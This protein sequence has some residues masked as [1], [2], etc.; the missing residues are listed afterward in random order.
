MTDTVYK[1]NVCKLNIQEQ[2]RGNE[3]WVTYTSENKLGEELAPAHALAVSSQLWA[4]LCHVCGQFRSIYIT[5]FTSA[6]NQDFSIPECW[7]INSSPNI[8]QN[9][10]KTIQ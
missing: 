5:K 6:A 3:V 7:L 8:Y 4:Q 9:T 1:G 2:K 10:I